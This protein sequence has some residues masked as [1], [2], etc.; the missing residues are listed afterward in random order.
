M[1]VL[2]IR[3]PGQR[4]TR[5]LMQHYGEQLVCVRYRYDAKAGKRYKTAEIIID[6]AEWTPPPAREDAPKPELKIDYLNPPQTSSDVGVKIFY[7]E[8]A[9]REQVGAAGGRWSQTE[10]LWHIPY[11]TAVT[12][13][14]EHRIAKR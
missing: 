6:E 12:L 10:K 5:R 2:A 13:G 3:R 7:R 9:L 1:H 8:A 14:L 4:G 11:D